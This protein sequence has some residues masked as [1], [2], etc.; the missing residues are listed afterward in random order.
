MPDES[1]GKTSVT[2][3][4][5]ETSPIRQILA[6]GGTLLV[7]TAAAALLIDPL[8]S[9]AIAAGGVVSFLNFFWLRRHLGAL[10]SVS[11][12]AAPLLSALKFLLRFAFLGVSVYLLLVVAKLPPA[13][14]LVGLSAPVFGSMIL[15]AS[16]LRKGGTS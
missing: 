13:G 2:G 1:F 5:P 16:N 9:A 8:Q 10:L 11:P 3:K 14:L 7:V 15:L 4:P 6:G 12:R